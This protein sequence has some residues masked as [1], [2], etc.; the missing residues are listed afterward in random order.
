MRVI[1]VGAGGGEIDWHDALKDLRADDVLLLEPGFYDLPQGIT[2]A[3]ITIKGTG[4][5]P[6]DTTILGYVS[7]SPDS[8]YVTLENLCINTIKDRNSLFVPVEANTYLSLRNCVIKGTNSDTAAIAA[9]GKITLELYSTKIINGSVSMFAD[10]DFRL[11]MN[12]T[13]IDYDSDEY[14]ALALEGRGT[15]IVN[16][17]HIHGSVNTFA[18]TNAELDINN[19]VV[20]Y[21]LLHGQTWMNMLNSEVLSKEDTCLYISDDCWINVVSSSFNGGIYIDKKAH[22]LIQNSSFNRMI[23]VNNAKITLSNTVVLA[24][25][26]FQDNVS[27]TARRVTFNGDSDYQYFLA[28]SGNA[29]LDGHDLILNSNGAD[30]AVQDDAH[31]STSVLASG[32]ASLKVECNKKPNV[33]I[34]GLK[35]TAKRK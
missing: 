8:R 18:Q 14:C 10:A 28:L 12:D 19:S 30:M 5:L 35:W 27:C 7:V 29:K 26:D 1:K 33:H 25:A 24:H 6:E 9:N 32:D 15:A 17:S 23:A 21:L 3:D 34:L 16:N 11:E 13:Y 22:V 4:T 2:L 31:L 20:D